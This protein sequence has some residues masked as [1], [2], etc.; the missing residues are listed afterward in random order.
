[1]KEAGTAVKEADTAAVKE[2]SAAV[3]AVHICEEGKISDP[4]GSIQEIIR[5]SPGEKDYRQ[6]VNDATMLA[7]ELIRERKILALRTQAPHPTILELPTLQEALPAA[8]DIDEEEAEASSLKTAQE[9]E[10]ASKAALTVAQKNEHAAKATLTSSQESEQAAK[11]ALSASQT[12][13]A[14]ANHRDEQLQAESMEEAVV[15]SSTMEEM[16][17]HCWA[18]N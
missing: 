12:Q 13:A 11:T 18:F 14:E 2:A 15:S 16:L 8:K 5:S 3:V 10:Q 1:M 6:V 17:Y 9:N 4:Q 7:C